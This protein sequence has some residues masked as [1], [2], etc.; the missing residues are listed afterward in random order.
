[1]AEIGVILGCKKSFANQKVNYLGI[2][3]GANDT[4]HEQRIM[5]L[6]KIIL[7]KHSIVK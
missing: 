6:K 2:P 5:D 1:M 4:V 3:T 7:R